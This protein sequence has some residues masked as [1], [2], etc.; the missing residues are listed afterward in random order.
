MVNVIQENTS[1]HQIRTTGMEKSD[2]HYAL[3]MEAFAIHQV[4][5]AIIPIY[6]TL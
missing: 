4:L 3:R 1:I 5:L 2:L 6:P